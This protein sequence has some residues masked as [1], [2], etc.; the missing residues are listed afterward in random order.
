MTLKNLLSA[1]GLIIEMLGVYILLVK[2]GAWQDALDWPGRRLRDFGVWLFE[3]KREYSSLAGLICLVL[4]A[5]LQIIGIFL[6]DQ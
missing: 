1:G 3:P 2:A 5:L 4:G 6:A